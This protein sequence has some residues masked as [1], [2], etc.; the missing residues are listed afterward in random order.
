MAQTQA[1]IPVF[2]QPW[3]LDIVGDQ[4]DVLLT[5]DQGIITAALPIVIE[6]KWGLR[7][8][9]NP[10]MTPYLGP[11]LADQASPITVLTQLWAQMP[12]YSSFELQC[13]PGFRD[14][15][16]FEDLGFTVKERVTY[17]LD[18]QQD[19]DQILGN[20][21]SKHRNLI[22]QADRV[23]RLESG[24]EFIK[25][26]LRMHQETYQRKNKKYPY[27]CD[28]IIRLLQ[29]SII[30]NQGKVFMSRNEQGMLTGGVFIIWDQQKAYLL[31]SGMHQEIVHPGAVRWLIYKALL[32]AKDLGLTIF[33]FEGSMDPGIASF[34]RR[35]GG[36][37]QQYL[38]L[39][40]YPS[41]IWRLKKRLL[42]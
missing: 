20:M 34:F 36:E 8:I 25:E 39:S 18:L 40:H 33:D 9:R 7:L 30:Q 32:F 31:M 27:P 37:E 1:W 14:A 11:L 17:F 5:T 2:A 41:A 23:N 26:L 4:W 16:F 29:A 21:H 13:Q 22:R 15:A 3:W 28:L 19:V 12:A 24:P 42:G 38:Q 10:L 35:F 6:Q